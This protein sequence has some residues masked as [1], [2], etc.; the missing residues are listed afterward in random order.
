MVDFDE[1]FAAL[2]G[3]LVIETDVKLID[4]KKM[5]TPDLSSL[6]ADT[7]EEL[8]DLGELLRPRTPRGIDLGAIY[9]GCLLELRSRNLV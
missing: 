5:T 6:Y 3:G 7:R 9:H 8:F 2:T 1:E 4:Y